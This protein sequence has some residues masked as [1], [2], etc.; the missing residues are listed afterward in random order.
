[1]TTTRNEPG[2]AGVA[3]A[4]VL[5]AALALGA[6]SSTPVPRFH[7]L[8]PAPGVGVV[9]AAD[10]VA[11]AGAIAW[12]VQPVSVPPGVDQAQWVVRSLDGS[13][14]VLEQE[15]WVGPLGEEIRAAVTARLSAHDTTIVTAVAAAA[16]AEINHRA[17]RLMPRRAA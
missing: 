7:S 11:P 13:L 6:C 8:T 15:R 4:L 3:S 2:R 5:G 10:K 12:E 14:V 1:M 16:A 9:P 17:G